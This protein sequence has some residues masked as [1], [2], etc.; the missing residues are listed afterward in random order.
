MQAASSTKM[1]KSSRNAKGDHLRGRSHSDGELCLKEEPDE[2]GAGS[3]GDDES[4]ASGARPPL[5]PERGAPAPA[6]AAKAKSPLAALTKTVTT[7][8]N[9]VTAAPRSA[10]SAAM[11]G[12]SLKPSSASLLPASP[13][14]L[15]SSKHPPKS[16]DIWVERRVELL[17]VGK[18][19]DVMLVYYDT[20]S[21]P[22]STT[23]PRFAINVGDTRAVCQPLVYP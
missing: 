2:Q 20:S 14:L 13:S 4:S 3:S 11:T 22:T 6:P 7:A 18:G 15:A 8:A 21:P 5:P 17:A 1:F 19:P 16:G 10:Y 12:A 23:E 9:A